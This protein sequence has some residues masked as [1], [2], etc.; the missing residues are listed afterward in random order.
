MIDMDHTRAMDTLA[1]EIDRLE[2]YTA[3]RIVGG[4]MVLAPDARTSVPEVYHSETEDVEIHGE[5]W[6]ALTG[7]TG[8]Y[9][10]HGAVMHP[11]EGVGRRIAE[12][13]AEIAE[14]EPNTV[15][16]IVPVEVY[17]D[18][19]DDEPEPAGWA[20]VHRTSE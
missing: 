12:R 3:F 16:A 6:E 7:M 10:Y 17:P 20:L 8:Q 13:L 18:E 14:D 11:S 1:E 2:F 15:F 4:M 19:E 9:S 5:G